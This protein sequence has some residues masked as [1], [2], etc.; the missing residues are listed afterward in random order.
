MMKSATFFSLVWFH[1]A[2]RGYT[3]PCSSIS[4]MLSSSGGRGHSWSQLMEEVLKDS[5]VRMQSHLCFMCHTCKELMEDDVVQEE[6]NATLRLI[7]EDRMW[8]K[9]ISYLEYFTKIPPPPLLHLGLPPLH[10]V[11]WT[12]RSTK[13]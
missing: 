13:S 1:V 4:F 9:V 8:L 10:G 6:G 3:R 11:S 7:E 12:Q 2:K 5:L